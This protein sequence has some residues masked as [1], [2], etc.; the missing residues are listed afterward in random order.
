MV[1]RA[2]FGASFE[3]LEFVHDERPDADD[4]LSMP[5]RRDGDVGVAPAPVVAVDE[6]PDQHP[7]V[8]RSTSR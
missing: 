2:A 5:A 3:A 1:P 7:S 8:T 4:A 6:R